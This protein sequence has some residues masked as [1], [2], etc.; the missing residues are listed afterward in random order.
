[1]SRMDSMVNKKNDTAMMKTV[2]GNGFA[3][4]VTQEQAQDLIDGKTIT[5]HWMERLPAR[6]SEDDERPLVQKSKVI[7]PDYVQF[8]IIGKNKEEKQALLDF[9]KAGEQR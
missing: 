7:S 4:W 8:E 3:S 1:M 6:W 9:L 5:I 2:C